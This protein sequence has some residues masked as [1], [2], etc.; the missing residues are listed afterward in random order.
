MW[1]NVPRGYAVRIPGNRQITV[2][3]S[4]DSVGRMNGIVVDGL[5]AGPGRVV[6]AQDRS[7]HSSAGRVIVRD[8]RCSHVVRSCVFAR[9]NQTIKR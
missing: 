1:I 4:V 5:V 8:F 6:D 7:E 3:W 2:S 9:K